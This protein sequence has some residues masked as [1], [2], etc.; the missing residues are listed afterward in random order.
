MHKIDRKYLAYSWNVDLASSDILGTFPVWVPLQS[1]D[2][3]AAKIRQFSSIVQ[4]A[5]YE[6]DL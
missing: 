1:M 6:T 2:H 4:W 3:P 5:A